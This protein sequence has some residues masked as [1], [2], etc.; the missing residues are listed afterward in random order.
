MD[1]E[2]PLQNMKVAKMQHQLML[3]FAAPAA[4]GLR[5]D[6]NEALSRDNSMP[7]GCDHFI[8]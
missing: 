2:H 7:G 3:S 5:T 6:H 8:A 1:V 4:E